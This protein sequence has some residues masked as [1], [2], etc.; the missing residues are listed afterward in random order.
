MR[1]LGSRTAIS[2]SRPAARVS[3]A[4]LQICRSMPSDSLVEFEQAEY[5]DESALDPPRPNHVLILVFYIA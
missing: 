2:C 3:T 4:F 1:V 5:D